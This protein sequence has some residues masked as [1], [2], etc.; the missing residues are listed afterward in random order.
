ME[1][2]LDAAFQRFVNLDRRRRGW[3]PIW[4]ASLRAEV[5][6]RFAIHCRDLVN[7]SGVPAPYRSLDIEGIP[8]AFPEGYRELAQIFIGMLD[9][10]RMLAAGGKRGTGK[11]TLG[12]GIVLK[13]CNL[14][15]PA[16]YRTVAE[17][18]QELSD[19]PWEK[20]QEIRRTYFYPEL[21]VLD[22]V[23]VRD[24]GRDWQDNE[25]TTLLDK[26]YRENK[27][28]IL[29]SNLLTSELHKNLGDSI[30]RRLIETGGPPI[31]TEWERIEVIKQKLELSRRPQNE[32]AKPPIREPDRGT[33]G[34]GTSSSDP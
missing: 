15:R 5:W 23:Q 30:W 34:D 10:P 31:R 21:L 16:V 1:G 22:E 17:M 3:N 20:K 18:F 7:R 32:P 6:A 2:R 25:L 9:A 26:R 19:A 8:S 13:F 28:T 14:G 33:P 29:L 12:Y 24:D 11:S 27:A 4:T